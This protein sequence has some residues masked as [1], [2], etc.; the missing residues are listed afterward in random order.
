MAR[1]RSVWGRFAL[2]LAF[3]GLELYMEMR[4][5]RFQD[6]HNIDIAQLMVSGLCF[7]VA[8][9]ILIGAMRG[10]TTE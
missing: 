2:M 4:S 5:P 1:G 3:G 8:L 9:S 6:I 10:K 7:G